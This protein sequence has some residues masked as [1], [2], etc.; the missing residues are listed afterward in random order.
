VTSKSLIGVESGKVLLDTSVESDNCFVVRMQQPDTVAVVDSK[1]II[2]IYQLKGGHVWAL[3]EHALP[4]L[5]VKT[6][7]K[8]ERKLKYVQGV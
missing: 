6:L 2:R 3:C 4:H 5:K 8:R 1:N 7:D